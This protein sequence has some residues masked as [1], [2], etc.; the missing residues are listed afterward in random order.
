MISDEEFE[1]HKHDYPLQSPDTK[2]KYYY[3]KKYREFFGE[4][5]EHVIPYYWLP[6]WV[7]EKSEPS[8]RVLED[9]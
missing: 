6:K 9:Y 3:C 2:E 8:A 7:G 1:T 4:K 5:A